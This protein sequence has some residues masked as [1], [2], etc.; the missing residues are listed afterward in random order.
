M[1]TFIAL[2]VLGTTACWGS[3]S[4]SDETAA[5]HPASLALS[6]A[7]TTRP[8]PLEVVFFEDTFVDSKGVVTPIVR[9]I[10]STSPGVCDRLKSGPFRVIDGE[11]FVNVRLPGPLAAPQKLAFDGTD[12][13]GVTLFDTAAACGSNAKDGPDNG[14]GTIEVTKTDGTL[15][16][17]VDVTL[18]SGAEVHGRYTA[19]ACPTAAHTNGLAS[20]PLPGDGGS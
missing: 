19:T 20:C 9:L 10:A 4:D 17:V 1:K 7:K 18:A 6:S 11:R 5:V 3:P 12:T 14:R 16:G 13:A 8:A 15:E 2:F